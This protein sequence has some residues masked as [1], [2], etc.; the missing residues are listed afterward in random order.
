MNIIDTTNTSFAAI[1]PATKT[2][3][4]ARR[5]FPSKFVDVPE[6]DGKIKGYGEVIVCKVIAELSF[7]DRI[8]VML[9]GRVA[10]DL[11]IA[12]EYA[13]GE[14]KTNAES[15]PLPPRWMTNK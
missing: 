4:I 3:K 13:V 1:D 2:Q 15:Y 10:V 11:K 9:S 8:R 14:T 7:M 12:C 6:P 5:L